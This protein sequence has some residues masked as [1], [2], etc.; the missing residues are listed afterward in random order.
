MGSRG[1]GWSSAPYWFM[2]SEV[3]ETRKDWDSERDTE[4]MDFGF[5]EKGASPGGDS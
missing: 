1:S 5:S 3:L 2:A 4:R